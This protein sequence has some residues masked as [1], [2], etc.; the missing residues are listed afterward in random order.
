M[1]AKSLGPPNSKDF[2][3]GPS[4]ET[5]SSVDNRGGGAECKLKP[6][7]PGHFA[8]YIRGPCMPVSCLEEFSKEIIRTTGKYFIYKNVRTTKASNNKKS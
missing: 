2:G 8:V 5:A 7:H 1:H 3:K 6:S 4:T